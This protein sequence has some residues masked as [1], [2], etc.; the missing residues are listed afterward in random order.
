MKIEYLP[1]IKPPNTVSKT[2]N[3]IYS[4]TKVHY[5]GEKTTEAHED[6]HQINSEIANGGGRHRDK[7]VGLYCLENL[8]F[9]LNEPHPL[10]IQQVA[11][12]I[13]QDFRGGVLGLYDLYCVQQAR[14]WGDRPFYLF[15]E[16]VAYTN[17]SIVA[18]EMSEA[19]AYNEKRWDSIHGAVYFT[20]FSL[21][22]V[23]MIKVDDEVKDFVTFQ[24]SRVK[25]LVE[26][27][28]KVPNLARQENV[29]DFAK[30]LGS[31]FAKPFDGPELLD[32]YGTEEYL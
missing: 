19:G 5:G 11:G 14:S 20:M 28:Q 3:D 8:A 7:N 31:E 21:V 2:Y 25:E 29:D 30:I 32:G 9:V 10:T 15:D 4:H 26:V 18:L 23:S 24:L 12:K 27:A 17:G 1:V 16:W 22:T 6:T 13:P